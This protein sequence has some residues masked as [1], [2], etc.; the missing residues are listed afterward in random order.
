MH[1]TETSLET[2][3]GADTA[4]AAAAA[5][6]VATASTSTLIMPCIHVSERVIL[7]TQVSKTPR[8]PNSIEAKLVVDMTC[9]KHLRP[10]PDLFRTLGRHQKT[11]RLRNEA[12]EP[13]IGPVRGR[14]RSAS[15]LH[16]VFAHHEIHTAPVPLA[17]QNKNIM[18]FLSNSVHT[19]IAL[20]QEE[21]NTFH[22]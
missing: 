2:T 19:L 1:A 10:Q 17:C 9:P 14:R 18:S 12:R 5:I 6:A 15:S 7:M 20:F 22:S 3:V 8:T 11:W 4:A 13:C 21:I 16:P